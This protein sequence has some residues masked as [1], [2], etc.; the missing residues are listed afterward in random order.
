MK[1]P[2]QSLLPPNR[3]T[4]PPPAPDSTSPPEA[5]RVE[6]A[7][8]ASVRQPPAAMRSKRAA[9]SQLSP[10]KPSFWFK[11]LQVMTGVLVVMAASVLVAWGLRRYLHKSPRFQVANVSVEGSNRL[12]AQRVTRLAEISVGHNIFDLDE[13][14]AVARLKRDPWIES[15]KVHKELPDSVHVQV[16]ERDP[17]LLASIGEKLFL[18]DAQGLLFKE[19]EPG[20]PVDFPVVTGLTAEQLADDRDGLSLLLRSALELLANLEQAHAAERFPI[21]ELHF[22]RMGH[23]SVVAGTEGLTLALGEPP[24]RAKVVKAVRLFAELHNRQGKAEAIFLDNRA[25]PERVVVR[26][27]HERLPINPEGNPKGNP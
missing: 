1:P 19:S 26:M 25:H 23:I 14:A 11:K 27:R 24:Y 5:S 12:T 8:P 10:K 13:D 3:R 21:Q 18:V 9:S 17:R 16:V 7:P 6:A 2:N 15:A 22:D 20:D 4:T